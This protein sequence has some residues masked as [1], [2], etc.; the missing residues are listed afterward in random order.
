MCIRD[1]PYTPLTPLVNGMNVGKTPFGYAFSDRSNVP[2]PITL[3]GNPVSDSNPGG[4]WSPFAITSGADDT[5]SLYWKNSGSSQ[6][7]Q[8]KLNLQGEKVS[9][10][11]LSDLQLFN[12]ESDL[13]TDLNNDG[14]IGLTYSPGAVSINGVNLGSTIYGIAIRDNTASPLQITYNGQAI[15]ALSLIHI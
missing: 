1:S 9:G 12:T 7:A 13:G 10:A 8:W 2:Q 3:A 4:G 11:L 14:T 15:Q 6:Y 5:Y